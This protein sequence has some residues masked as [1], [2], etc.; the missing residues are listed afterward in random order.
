MNHLI[1]IYHDFSQVYSIYVPRSELDESPGVKHYQKLKYFSN[2]EQL[3]RQ[4]TV[5]LKRSTHNL[6]DFDVISGS[7][8]FTKPNEVI[9]K[10]EATFMFAQLLKEV[11]LGMTDID[12][13]DMIDYCRTNYANN[14]RQLELIGLF[15]RDY[16]GHT[17]L[18]WYSLDGFLY[19]MLNKA[20][21]TQD[22]STMYALRTFIRDLHNQLM[23]L[24]NAVSETEPLILY[25]GQQMYTSDFNKLRTNQGGLLSV[26]TFLSTSK[27][28]NVA[29]TYAGT[30]N[31]SSGE[32]ATLFRITVN[33]LKHF[34]IPLA[35]IK[36]ISQFT[37]E[38][39]YLFSMGSVFRINKIENLSNNIECVHLELTSDHDPQL[40]QMT[41]Y[42][43]QKLRSRYDL[44]SLGRLM[45]EMGNFKKAEELYLN[46]VE[47]ETN[48]SNL[49]ALHNQ[50]GALYDELGNHLKALE[51]YQLC[52][53]IKQSYLPL[54]DASFAIS[55]TN[56]GLAH[57]NLERNDLA[58]EHLQKALEIA[59][60]APEMNQELLGSIHNNIAGILD[61]QGQ[62]DEP[63]EHY[64]KGL[65]YRLACLPDIHPDIATSYS[66]IG[67]FYIEHGHYE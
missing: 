1:S 8:D 47:R 3:M 58:I 49:A 13:S 10:Q 56:I 65:E 25:R 67:F 15:E 9:N 11:F 28:E 14:P 5:D 23:E 40:S 41:N 37:E 29:L 2:Q 26:K 43:R 18:W 55:Y 42:I 6:I 59:S 32:I 20:L 53:T 39:E 60:N 4:L 50:L 46:A 31:I 19:R 27:N 52:T 24:S 22:I 30:T 35:N 51:H 33:L 17:P 36:E 38:N 63:L 44:T 34:H 62:F 45:W 7:A 16:R 57:Q 21:R 12:R 64:R 66:D 54:N 61:E 48:S